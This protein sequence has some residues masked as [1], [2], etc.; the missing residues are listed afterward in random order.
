[1]EKSLI[2][3]TVVFEND[4][5]F[6]VFEDPIE[7][8]GNAPLATQIRLGKILQ[9]FARPVDAIDDRAGRLAGFGFT[10]TIGT[11]A[12]GDDQQLRRTGPGDFR[13]DPRGPFRPIENNEGN[14]CLQN[15]NF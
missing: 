15:L 14:R 5:F 7:A 9:H 13:K 11:R 4:R 8:A 1:M 10:F 2:R 12:I 3:Q 6:H